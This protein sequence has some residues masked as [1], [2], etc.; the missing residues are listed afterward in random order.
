MDHFE[1]LESVFGLMK[2]ARLIV[3]FV[4]NHS[5]TNEYISK[6]IL[7]EGGG[8]GKYGGLVMDMTIRW[9]SSFVPLDRL[10]NHK[11]ILNNMFAFP[12]SI[13]GLDDKQ[14]KRLKELSLNQQEWKLIESLGVILKP[15]FDATTVLSGQY[16]PTMALS[17]YIFRLLQ[18]FLESASDD[19]LVVGLKE[20]LLFWFNMHCKVKLPHGQLEIMIVSIV[21]HSS[22]TKSVFTCA[23]Y[24][25]GQLRLRSR[26][27]LPSL[28]S[29]KKC[30]C[31]L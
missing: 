9:N 11:E 20:S 6:S 26:V 13:P 17:F 19:P 3:K 14:R 15:F 7:S 12:N 28:A 22:A 25:D 24:R 16:Y 18:H 10:V 23:S 27:E 1:L 4:R 5:I 30:F 29:W 21:S 8:N 2:K 31:R